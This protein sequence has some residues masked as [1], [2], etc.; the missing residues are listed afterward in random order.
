MIRPVSGAV[1][2]YAYG[3]PENSRVLRTS[4]AAMS[5]DSVIVNRPSGN[6]ADQRAG[7]SPA[8]AAEPKQYDGLKR[9]TGQPPG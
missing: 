5:T 8:S 3:T 2:A 9:W 7:R 4:S 6:A 1:A